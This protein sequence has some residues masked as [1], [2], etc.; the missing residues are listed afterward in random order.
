MRERIVETADVK[1]KKLGEAAEVAA[2]H[3]AEIELI[4]FL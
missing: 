3:G 2:V 4:G 1:T